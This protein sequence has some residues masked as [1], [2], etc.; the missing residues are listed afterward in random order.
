[1]DFLGGWRSADGI[2]CQGLLCLI[3]PEPTSPICLEAESVSLAR[4]QLCIFLT[5]VTY[6]GAITDDYYP[7]IV[8]RNLEQGFVFEQR[9]P[10]CH[11]LC[12]CASVC[13]H[14][15]TKIEFSI[16]WIVC[17]SVFASGLWTCILLHVNE[18]RRHCWALWQN[19]DLML[20]R[21]LW[22]VF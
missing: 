1:M 5:A 11:H 2:L 10:S 7:T 3:L 16:P 20:P 17:L 21:P 19:S 9:K 14:P 8:I 12:S 13:W 22:C 15:L 4:R 6:D 18:A